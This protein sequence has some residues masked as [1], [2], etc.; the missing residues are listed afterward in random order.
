MKD[1]FLRICIGC[2]AVLT[3]DYLYGFYCGFVGKTEDD[4]T[5]GF[6]GCLFWWI[7]CDAFLVLG[8]DRER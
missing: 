4:F 6:F 5:R 3:F 2:F 8:K 7:L 1:L